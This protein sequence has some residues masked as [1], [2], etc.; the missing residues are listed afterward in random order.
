MKKILL[1]VAASAF[2][3][4]CNKLASNEFEIAGTIDPSLNGK[5]VILE[6]QGTMGYEPIDTVKIEN[7]K[8]TIK[9]KAVEPELH[10]IQVEGVQGKAE[11]ILEEGEI[12][13]K[14]DKDSI[15]KTER[16]GTYN[17]E[18]LT[19]YYNDISKLRQKMMG[20][21]KANQA[22]M[23]EAYKKQDTVVMNRLN[24]TYEA[25]G[26]DMRAIADKFIEK[27]PKA[28][29][30][31]LLL[32]QAFSMKPVPYA[33]MKKKY[34]ELDPE[35][36]KV[37]AAKELSEFIENAKK[38]EEPAAAKTTVDVGVTAPDFS[39]TTPDGK[40]LSLK[41]SLGKVTIVDFWASWCKPCRMENP[42]VVALYNEL[43]TKGLNIIGV[44]LDKDA[45]KWKEAIAADKLTWNHV[46]N[47]KFW[48]EP[49]A[50]QYS[51]E[52]IPATFILDA[53][54]KVV[55]KDLRGAEL[56]AKVAELLAK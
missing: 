42:N 8:F 2:V 52:S 6:K 51:V 37:K 27:N 30:T 5:N 46:S 28:Y 7:G 45:A 19:E 50:K 1:M 55:A 12:D 34:D 16:T 13:M 48:D 54:G 44:S 24:K 38:A 33:E 36:K 20:F 23:M 43:H 18:K 17:N 26:K 35:I 25:I 3:V 29:I 47:L 21:Q 39:A 9:G 11:F 56:K 22:E 53:T 49:I 15:F 10:F 31:V 14:V 41:E 32:K 40:K 4:S